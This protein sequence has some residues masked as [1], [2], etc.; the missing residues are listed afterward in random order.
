MNKRA[1]KVMILVSYF[2]PT[3]NSNPL[4]RDTSRLGPTAPICNSVSGS[5]RRTGSQT[6]GTTKRRK[7]KTRAN[8]ARQR[9][10]PE[11]RSPPAA[12]LERGRLKARRGASLGRRAVVGLEPHQ[13]RLCF[14]PP[15]AA[16]I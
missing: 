11:P 2:I 8:R 13:T 7:K 6:L 4:Q 14:T 1:K 12:V 3:V 15:N 10:L 16:V 9:R 5:L